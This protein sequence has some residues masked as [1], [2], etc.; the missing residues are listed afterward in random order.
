MTHPW[1]SDGMGRNGMVTRGVLVAS[2][3]M[4]SHLLGVSCASS[5]ACIAVGYYKNSSEVEVTLAERWNGSEWKVQSTPNP[6]EQQNA[7]WKVCRVRRRRCVWRRQ[8]QNS[9]G[10]RVTLAEYWNGSK[11]SIQ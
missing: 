11:W 7:N 8:L 4:E 3:E 10:V 9:S 5:T 1:S 2:E 6:T